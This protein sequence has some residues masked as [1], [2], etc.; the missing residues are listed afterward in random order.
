M[1][2]WEELAIVSRVFLVVGFLCTDVSVWLVSLPWH[3]LVGVS[4]FRE[5]GLMS[6]VEK[7]LQGNVLALI[8]PLGWIAVALAVS[9]ALC[10]GLFYGLRR[11][12]D[13]DIVEQEAEALV[14]KA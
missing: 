8:M 1:N 11:S 5:F 6:S 13:D 10:L 3:L 7:D 2:A 12:D 4:C 9:A 14:S